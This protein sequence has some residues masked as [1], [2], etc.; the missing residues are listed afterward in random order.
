MK[1]VEG[2]N[3]KQIAE[4]INPLRDPER[5]KK[6]KVS[7]PN[8]NIELLSSGTITAATFNLGSYPL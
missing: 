5:F 7:I 3:L 2:I 8:D 4:V 6:F 1:G